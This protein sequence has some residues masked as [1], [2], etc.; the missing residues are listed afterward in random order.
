MGSFSTEVQV[1]VELS[2]LH[3]VLRD[4]LERVH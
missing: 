4:Y 2:Y 3:L 1:D